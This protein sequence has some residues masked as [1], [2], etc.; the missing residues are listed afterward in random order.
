MIDLCM[1]VIMTDVMVKHVMNPENTKKRHHMSSVVTRYGR[2]R[3][4]VLKVK[5]FSTGSKGS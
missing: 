1:L 2:V 3:H 4:N 5:E